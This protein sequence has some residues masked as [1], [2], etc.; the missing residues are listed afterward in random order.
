MKKVEKSLICQSINT[1]DVKRRADMDDCVYHW[2]DSF[3][4]Q[5]FYQIKQLL[6]GKRGDACEEN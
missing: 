4:W 1:F 2:D 5:S 6:N 3:N